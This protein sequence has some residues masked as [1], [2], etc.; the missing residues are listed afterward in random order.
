MAAKKKS[1]NPRTIPTDKAQVNFN[2]D[3]E[4]LEKVNAIAFRESVNKTELFT[5]ALQKLVELYEQ[6]NGKVH[7]PKSKGE[8]LKEL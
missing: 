6:K 5:L 7:L 2:V 4:L 8:G 1:P 3:A